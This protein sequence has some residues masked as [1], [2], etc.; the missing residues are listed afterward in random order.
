V[1][2]PEGKVA[3]VMDKDERTF[4]FEAGTHQ[5]PPQS[6]VIRLEEADGIQE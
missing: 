2:V 6:A 5:M 1:I 4:R 3:V